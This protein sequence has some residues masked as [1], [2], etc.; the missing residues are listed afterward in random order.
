MGSVYNTQ[1]PGLRHDDAR[2]C[3]CACVCVRICVR[4][5]VCVHACVSVTGAVGKEVSSLYLLGPLGCFKDT[6]TSL[7]PPQ[8][9][10]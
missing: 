3:P 6:E 2:V 10:P 1:H 8:S 5:G 9:L 7:F 4:M